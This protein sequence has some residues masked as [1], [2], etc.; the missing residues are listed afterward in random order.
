MQET[1]TCPWNH[2]SS[3]S[4][5]SNIFLDFTLEFGF[6][7]LV[8]FPTSGQNTL[9]VF[10]TNCPSF[11]YTC[12]PLTGISDHEIICLTSAVDVDLHQVV[13]KKNYFWQ[14]ADFDDIRTIANNLSEEFLNE[15]DSDIPIEV[16]WLEFKTINNFV[17][18]VLTTKLSVKCPRQP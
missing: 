8:D 11:E 1:S 18:S 6:N 2:Y 12:Q 4:S 9:D 13:H 16:L 10:I 3:S 7:Q 14:R 5:L 17:R 15:F